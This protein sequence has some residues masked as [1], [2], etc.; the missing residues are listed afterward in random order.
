MFLKKRMQD[1]RFVM[2][3]GLYFLVGANLFQWLSR[4]LTQHP[5]VRYENL[6]D[7]VN[8]LLFG[9]AIGLL[10]LSVWRHGREKRQA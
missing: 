8:G 3:L 10:I 6:I 7:G 1:H 9:I 2:V 4:R 5:S